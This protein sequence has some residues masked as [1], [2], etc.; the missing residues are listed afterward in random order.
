MNLQIKLRM[1]EP[2][3][4]LKDGLMIIQQNQLV[5][6]GCVSYESQMSVRINFFKTSFN[7]QGCTLQNGTSV[8]GTPNFI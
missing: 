4:L 1:S 2:L 8:R 7:F 3:L 6:R 5:L